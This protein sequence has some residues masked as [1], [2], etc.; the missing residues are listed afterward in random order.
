MVLWKNTIPI[1]KTLP[2]IGCGLKGFLLE[3][4]KQVAGGQ[5]IVTSD[6]H[7]QYLFIVRPSRT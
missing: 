1:V 5:G 6:P 7:N 4:A 3:Y 2:V